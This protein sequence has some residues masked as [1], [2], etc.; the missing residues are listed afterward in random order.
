MITGKEKEAINLEGINTI[1]D[2]ISKLDKKYP[3]LKD[4]FIPQEGMFNSRTAITVRRLGEPSVTIINKK[5]EIKAGDTVF[6][7]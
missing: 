3:G 5:Q 1:E 7:W 6:L 2:L 4:I